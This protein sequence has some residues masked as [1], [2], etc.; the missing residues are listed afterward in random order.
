MIPVQHGVIDLNRD[1][2]RF[3]LFGLEKIKDSSPRNLFCL[4]IDLDLHEDS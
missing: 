4:A 1:H 3:D 2:L